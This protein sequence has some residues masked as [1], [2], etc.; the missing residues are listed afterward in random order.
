M[1]VFLI[2]PT[3]SDLNVAKLTLFIFIKT[4]F[5]VVTLVPVVFW[6]T[7]TEL[8]VYEMIIIITRPAILVSNIIFSPI[9]NGNILS[10]LRTLM[11]DSNLPPPRRGSL[12][13]FSALCM[14]VHTVFS[15][16]SRMKSA[17]W[18]IFLHVLANCFWALEV[19][20]AQFITGSAVAQFLKI[21]PT[22]D[23]KDLI[24]ELNII[25]ETY[26]NFKGAMSFSLFINFILQTFPAISYTYLSIDYF[27]T[28]IAQ[29]MT[30]FL[31]SVSCYINLSFLALV[32]NDA[33]EHFQTVIQKAW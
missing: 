3:F 8:Y 27:Y 10:K 6:A 33:F 9:A 13:L 7:E 18:R 31:F 22:T 30:A 26:R 20:G 19:A 2:P 32:A 1:K 28:G 11:E 24:L 23:K 29:V 15:V 5:V 25:L 21:K 4:L 17:W 14:L 12:I 16:Y